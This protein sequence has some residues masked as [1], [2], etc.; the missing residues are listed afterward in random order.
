MR[1]Y[2]DLMKKNNYHQ[3]FFVIV[4]ICYII[5][6]VQTPYAIAPIVDSIFGNIIVIILAFFILVHSNPILGIIF[7]F[8]AYE[9][10]RRSS[11]KTGTSAIKRF[12]P[13]QMKMDSHLSA[14]N[15]FPVTL[16]EQ[17]VKQMAPLVETAGPNHLHYNPAT[18]Y[19]HN[20]MNVTDTTSVI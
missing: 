1:P 7:V 6:N 8:A 14:F 4:L 5:F 16:E 13:S 18:S 19:T 15:Q 10:I 12:L 9:F 17:M 3:L 20:A 11:D 2:E